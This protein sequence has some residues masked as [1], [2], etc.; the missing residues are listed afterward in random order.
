MLAFPSQTIRGAW[1]DLQGIIYILVSCVEIGELVV[2]FLPLCVR[3]D[4]S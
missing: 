2:V 3:S 4:W 1:K